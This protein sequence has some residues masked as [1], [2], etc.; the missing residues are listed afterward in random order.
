MDITRRIDGVPELRARLDAMGFMVRRNILRGALGAAGRVF[1]DEVRATVPVRTG[2][3]KQTIRVSTRSFSNG[4][5]RG[6]VVMGGVKAPYA[7]PL[8]YGQKPHMIYPKNGGKL[9]L[10]GGKYADWVWHKGTYGRFIVYNAFKNKRQ[11]A[12]EAF[13]AYV[14]RRIDEVMNDPTKAYR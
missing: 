13:D 2:A 14:R 7:N 8:E 11:Q 5:V 9:R 6:R 10:Y 4:T 3:L 12:V 1:R